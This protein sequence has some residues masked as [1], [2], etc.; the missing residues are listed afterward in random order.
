MPGGLKVA[1]RTS[2]RDPG[3]ALGAFLRGLHD[4]CG[5]HRLAGGALIE[6]MQL[7]LA[8]FGAVLSPTVPNVALSIASVI[9]TQHEFAH[10]TGSAAQ[11]PVVNADGC[12]S[13]PRHAPIE[14]PAVLFQAASCTTML[15]DLALQ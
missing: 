13:L 7:R 14:L 15:L 6:R 3:S 5:L 2:V 8:A 11:H 12:H 1:G 9:D 4:R 10:P